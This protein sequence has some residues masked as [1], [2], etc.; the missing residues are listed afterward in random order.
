MA[1]RHLRRAGI[2]NAARHYAAHLEHS[3]LARVAVAAIQGLSEL[4]AKEY[5]SR[6]IPLATHASA[7]VREAV[8]VAIERLGGSQP[9][10]VL[11]KLVGDSSRRVA[12]SAGLILVRSGLDATE[13]DHLWD[14]AVQRSD[15]GLL[16]VWASLDRWVQLLY[17]A[18]GLRS[19]RPTAVDLAG[20]L[21]DRID[22]RWNQAFT[23]PLDSMRGPLC[24]AL[25][26]ALP[27]MPPGRARLLRMSL[28]PYL[29]DL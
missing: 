28:R 17:A 29:P 15:R 22:A 6:V 21:R 1:Q 27:M 25:H 26:E 8:C 11:F 23:P 3:A 5:L 9:R 12:H 7:R 10:D 13:L 2:D 16:P 19:G 4:D 14:C 20:V 24:D 18:R